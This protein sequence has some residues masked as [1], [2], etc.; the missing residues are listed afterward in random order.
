MLFYP[1]DNKA[2]FENLVQLYEEIHAM[3]EVQR[4]TI[5]VGTKCDKE[6]DRQV[7]KESGEE[8]ARRLNA[9]HIETSAKN[10]INVAESFV[11]LVNEVEETNRRNDFHPKTPRRKKECIIC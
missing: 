11:A 7:S 10:N 5:L 2:A 1:I 3:I 6:T 8:L 9:L 4:P